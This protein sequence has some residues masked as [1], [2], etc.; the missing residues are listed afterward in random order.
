MPQ[1]PLEKAIEIL[2]EDRRHHSE[3][4]DLDTADAIRLSIEAIKRF[5][6]LR[7]HASLEYGYYQGKLPGEAE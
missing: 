3:G 7:R 5:L 1:M 2:Q 6:M 4:K